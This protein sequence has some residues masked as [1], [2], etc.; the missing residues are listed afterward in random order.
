MVAI[1]ENRAAAPLSR[2][3]GR[4]SEPAP[5]SYRGDGGGLGSLD[6]PVRASV[7]KLPPARKAGTEGAV[8]SDPSRGPGGYAASPFS[9]D[10][11]D[12]NVPGSGSSARMRP[13]SSAIFF[14]CALRRRL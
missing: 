11:A 9:L 14:A 8:A 5:S 3:G 6:S 7:S 2:A 13:S 10:A 1:G 12:P 4:S